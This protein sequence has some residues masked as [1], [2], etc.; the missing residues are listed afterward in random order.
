MKT[1]N[2]FNSAKEKYLVHRK[3]QKFQVSFLDWT[4]YFDWYFIV[5]VFFVLVIAGG[6]LA[7]YT[8]ENVIQVMNDFE[9]IEVQDQQLNLQNYAELQKKY[10]N[11]AEVLNRLQ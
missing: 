1:I 2:K 3:Q 11:K 8:Y 9:N 10:S 4:P 7:F 6:F 5:S